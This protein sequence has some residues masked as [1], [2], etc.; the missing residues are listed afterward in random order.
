M[1][2]VLCI[3]SYDQA[4]RCLLACLLLPAF[5]LAGC[6]WRISCFVC[7]ECGKSSA[8][9]GMPRQQVF[10]VKHSSYFFVFES[11]TGES[12]QI[13]D[14]STSRGRHNQ[15]QQATNWLSPKKR[16]WCSRSSSRVGTIFKDNNG[17]CEWEYSSCYS[18]CCCC[19]S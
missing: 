5:L 2:S 11:T 13:I 16:S 9:A 4:F 3:I 18:S 10:E 7:L 8:R 19:R 17:G 6:W 15:N 14:L 1:A 12:T